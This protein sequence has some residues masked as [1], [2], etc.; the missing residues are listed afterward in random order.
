MDKVL[1]KIVSDVA[2]KYN[3]DI[4]QVEH[5]LVMP[6]KMMR[7]KIQALELRGHLYD[8]VKDQKTNFNMPVLFKMY[9]NGY[10]IN[11]LNGVKDDTEEKDDRSGADV[12]LHV[13]D[14]Q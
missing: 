10:K 1:T 11:K 12:E 2:T 9:L 8:E 6:Y 5:I 14:S 13:S 4:K 3:L 7:E